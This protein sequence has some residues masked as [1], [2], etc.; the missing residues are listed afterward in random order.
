M[1]DHAKVEIPKE[2]L[3]PSNGDYISTIVDSVFLM[4]RHGGSD[5]QQMENR[6]ILAPTLDV[7]NAVNEYMSD[8]HVAESKTYLNCDTV[9]KS[10]TTNGILYDMHTPEFLIG[11]KASGTPNHS[12]TLKN[13]SPVMLLR[14]IDHSMGL[15]NGTRLIITRLSDYVVEAKIVGGHN[16]GNV[17]LIPR[18]SMTPTDTRLPFKFQRRQF[19][20]ILSYAMTINKSQGL[21]LTHVDLLLKKPVFVHGQLYVAASRISNSAG[22][23]ILIPNEGGDYSNYTT[24]VVYHEVFN[25]L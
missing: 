10:D 15:C 5:L 19:P 22:L 17:V 7:V 25:N 16:A 21:T 12:L 14:N 9:C 2:M 20:L 8:L 1:M 18:M 11:L 13:G 6:A 24:N 4:F 23:K 3:L